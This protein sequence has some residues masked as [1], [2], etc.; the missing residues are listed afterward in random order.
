[1]TNLSVCHLL[2]SYLFPI[3]YFSS[4]DIL[5][6][7]FHCTFLLMHVSVLFIVAFYLYF[8]YLHY[9]FL[10]LLRSASTRCHFATT[11]KLCS[12]FSLSCLGKVAPAFLPFIFLIC[13]LFIF[14]NQNF[15]FFTKKFKLYFSI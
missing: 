1:M 2:L 6:V 8:D 10:L 11:W 7:S 14:Y 4:F 9:S 13:K 15:Y 3:L 12:P 5:L